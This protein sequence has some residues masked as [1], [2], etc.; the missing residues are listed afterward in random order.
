MNEFDVKAQE[1]DSNKRHIERAITVAGSIKMAISL[2]KSMSALEYG[3]GTGLLSMELKDYLGSVVLMDNSEGMIR[4][5]AS[6][7]MDSGIAN[8]TPVLW[9]LEK[10][11]YKGRFDLIYSLM[12]LHHVNNVDL[13]L[14]R[15]YSML[16]NGGFIAIADL[17]PEDGSFHGKGFSGHKG[18]DPEM[19]RYMLISKGFRNVKHDKC[20]IIS[21]T[22]IGGEMMDFPLFLLTGEK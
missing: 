3:A 20:Y 22:L 14:S 21:K 5:T 19:L 12:V 2:N 17:Y 7:I 4:V 6:K 16:N 11:V 9:D 8:M 18:F 13:I 10:D 15:F 1:W